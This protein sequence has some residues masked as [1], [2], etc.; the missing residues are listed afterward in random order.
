MK[1]TS[2]ILMALVISAFAIMSSS[3]AKEKGCMDPE[4][5]NYNP[6]AEEDDGSCE[7]EGRV[8]FWYNEATAAFLSLG[9]VTALTYYVD[10]TVVGSSAAS[11]VWTGAPDC[12]QDGSVTVTKNL[13]NVKS[14]AYTYSVKDQDG[15]ELWSGTLNF[16]ANTCVAVQLSI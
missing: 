2:F 5:I 10:G 6:D 1:K 8:V 7:Y 4:S 9:D 11:V 14:K 13:G 16:K 15:N 12:G 3:C